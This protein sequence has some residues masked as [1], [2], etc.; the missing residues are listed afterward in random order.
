MHHS[1]MIQATSTIAA[2]LASVLLAAPAYAD[3][4]I[5]DESSTAAPAP[6][7][8]SSEKPVVETTAP[9]AKPTTETTTKPSTDTTTKPST[10]ATTAPATT[11]AA[12]ATTPTTPVA[13]PDQPDVKTPDTPSVFTPT[14]NT[15]TGDAPAGGGQL[16]FTGPGDV[17]LAIVLALLA[18]SAGILFMA[19]AAG[20]AQIDGLNPRGM[21]SPSGFKLAYRELLRQQVN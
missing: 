12:P 18:G 8:T 10:E 19:G 6:A 16:P 15:P 1:R 13:L 21:D 7:A 3:S 9:A 11:T 5:G 14:V 2:I 17:L 20:R 4:G